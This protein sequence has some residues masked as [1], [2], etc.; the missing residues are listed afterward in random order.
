LT[1]YDLNHGQITQSPK[2]SGFDLIGSLG[3][4]LEIGLVGIQLLD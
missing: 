4:T 1:I 3:G 2:R